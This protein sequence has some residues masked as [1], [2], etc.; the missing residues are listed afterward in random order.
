MKLKAVAIGALA[1]LALTACGGN[2]ATGTSSPDAGASGDAQGGD[3]SYKIGIAL[4]QTHPALD[5]VAAG[6]KEAFEE[7]G[8]EFVVW[9]DLREAGG[10]NHWGRYLG[11][12]RADGTPKGPLWDVWLDWYRRGER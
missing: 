6:F 12:W 9:V 8:V 10:G 7:A 3:K 1:A 4:I 11:L 2:A 5:A